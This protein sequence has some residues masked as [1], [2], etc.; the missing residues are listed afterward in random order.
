MNY[1]YDKNTKEFLYDDVKQIDPLATRKAGKNV[2]VIYPNCTDIEPPAKEEGK[3]AVW[4]DDQW[5]MQIDNRGLRYFKDNDW[6]TIDKIGEEV[7]EGG[8][9][10]GS[11]ELKK[12]YAKDLLKSARN[13]KVSEPVEHKKKLI[14]VD[15]S[16]VININ[17]AIA[18]VEENSLTG[19]TIDWRTA[20]N[21]Y[22][23]L[24]IGDL[25]EINQKR[26]SKKRIAFKIF[27]E[28][29][30]REDLHE[31]DIQQEFNSR[32]QEALNVS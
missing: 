31:I 4:M 7:P 16:S 22:V 17:D 6:K 27:N 5:V 30:E 10:K 13:G 25:K 21:S 12:I 15:T 1:F 20:D 18:E 19:V 23:T 11:I 28:F 9:L 32:F 8:L 14:Q 29:L 3:T 24:N 26:R 2:H